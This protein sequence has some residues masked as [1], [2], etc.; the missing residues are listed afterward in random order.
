MHACIHT[1][2]HTYI[3]F[4]VYVLDHHG[5]ATVDLIEAWDY[6]TVLSKCHIVT[7][8]SKILSQD[9]SD[10]ISHKCDTQHHAHT[11]N[12]LC[13]CV[14]DIIMVIQLVSA[15]LLVIF[16]IDKDRQHLF[17]AA[18]GHNT[19]RLG[20][21]PASFAIYFYGPVSLIPVVSS[22]PTPIWTIYT[23]HATQ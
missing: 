6:Q 2:I 23:V 10:N 14:C 20:L 16:L 4:L 7:R 15:S 8:L 19:R 5:Y 13:V 1:Y 11:Y 21:T 22:P 9:M 17:R 12:M 3:L 18:I